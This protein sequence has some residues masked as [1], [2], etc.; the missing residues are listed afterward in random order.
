MNFETE[1]D[2]GAAVDFE[3]WKAAFCGAVL[4]AFGERIVCAGYRAAA[5]AAKRAKRAISTRC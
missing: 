2:T 3:A 5:R 4:A 1:A